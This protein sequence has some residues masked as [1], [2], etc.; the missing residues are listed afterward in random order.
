VTERDERHV[1]EALQALTG[2]L[3]V[4][5]DD[6]I[7]ATGRLQ[8]RLE[9]PSPRRRLLLL[10]AGVAAAVVLIGYVALQAIDRHGDASPPANPP[11]HSPAADLKAALQADAYAIPAG[12]FTTGARPTYPQLAGLWLL[13][14]PYSFAMFVARDGDWRMDSPTATGAFGT[15]R[16]AGHRLTRRLDD[17]SGCARSQPLVGHSTSWGAAL[18]RDGSLRLQLRNTPGTCTPADDR[19]VWDRVD[20]GSPVASYLVAAAND[21][22][23]QAAPGQFKWER[24]YVA[25]KTGHVLEVTPDG[26][27]RYYDALRVR[28]DA[29]DRGELQSHPGG[30]VRGSCAGGDFSGILQVARI[31]SVAGYVF[32]HDAIRIRTSTTGCASGV[33][34]EGVWVSLAS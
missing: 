28:L 21:V 26:H 3:I 29:A 11:T 34:E 18:A 15:S 12:R 33:A 25:P 7:E 19:E 1:I 16:L 32:P 6:I 30:E 8:D 5:E 23:W 27:Y 14:P 24:V 10:V 4:T 22:E 31:P 13:R 9:P 17:R 2:G 20:P